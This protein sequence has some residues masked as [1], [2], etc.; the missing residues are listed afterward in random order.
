LE[1]L[2]AMGMMTMVTVTVP[3]VTMTTT[4]LAAV[5][6]GEAK[7]MVVT[8][9]AGGTDNN[10]LKMPAEE[11][12]EAAVMAAATEIVTATETAPKTVMTMM[13][14]PTLTPTTVH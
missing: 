9:M 6:A 10:Q 2:E 3:T 7:T 12:V 1:M 5:A 14:M 8:A 4:T 13:P 11:M